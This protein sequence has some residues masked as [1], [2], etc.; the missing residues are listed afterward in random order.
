MSTHDDRDW[1][2]DELAERGPGE[3]EPEPPLTVEEIEA[4]LDTYFSDDA[5]AEAEAAVFLAGRAVPQ[6]LAD[7][8]AAREKLARYEEAPTHEEWTVTAN[9]AT[10]PDRDAW[11]YTANAALK[12]AARD[13]KQAWRR[14]VTHKP[15]V[16][17]PWQPNPF[18][19]EPPF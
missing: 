15:V 16:I 7:L 13:G 18:S 9:A 6:L 11:F 10:P 17:Q 12:I 3:P 2:L 5:S 14:V 1:T 8:R 19:T 4:A